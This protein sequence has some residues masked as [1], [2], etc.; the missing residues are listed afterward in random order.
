MNIKPISQKSFNELVLMQD[1]KL[2][3][4]LEWLNHTGYSEVFEVA[5]RLHYRF[6]VSVAPRKASIIDVVT[7][8]PL[9]GEYRKVL[10]LV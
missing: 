7:T 10:E 3:S 4:R 2:D 9:D 5:G 1:A 6:K 8:V